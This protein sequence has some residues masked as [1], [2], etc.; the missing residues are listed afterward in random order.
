[1][2]TVTAILFLCGGL[3]IFGGILHVIR[4]RPLI[5][6]CMLF[7]AILICA[8]PWPWEMVRYLMPLNALASVL[9]IDA[10]L[11]IRRL[12]R[13]RFSPKLANVTV[14]LGLG[15]LIMEAAVTLTQFYGTYYSE[16]APSSINET[17]RQKLFFYRPSYA[18]LD[19]A[20]NSL[21]DRARPT[22]ILASS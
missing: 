14:A 18:A 13:D 20:L 4:K 15:F 16:S 9:L 7:S 11:E 22:D 1:R 21:R 5:P 12:L 3:V 10:V 6:L 2:R 8:T 17:R 19:N